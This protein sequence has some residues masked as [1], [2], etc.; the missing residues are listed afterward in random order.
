MRLVPS[1]GRI[2]KSPFNHH[3]VGDFIRNPALRLLP[4]KISTFPQAIVKKE[5]EPKRKK[6]T[7]AIP[8][9][10]SKLAIASRTI[11]GLSPDS[12]LFTASMTAHDVEASRYSFRWHNAITRTGLPDPPTIFKG[13]AITMEPVSGSLSKFV[14]LARP[15]LPWPCM[16]K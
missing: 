4:M 1:S 11:R 12:D 9:L 2:R 14:R 13:A 6:A 16:T 3:V 5:K 15:N 7:A 10:S 8:L